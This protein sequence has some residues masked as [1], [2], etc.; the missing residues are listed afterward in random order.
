MNDT[1][2]VV[3][4]KKKRKLKPR[5]K[6][7]IHRRPGRG[8]LLTEAEIARALGELPRTVRTWRVK[9]FVPSLTLGHKTIRYR[10][11]PVL[12]ALE[13]R[14]IKKRYFFQQPI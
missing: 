11:G 13:K 6:W 9:G 2:E 3:A 7:K 1:D 14:Q 10:L 12:E 5:S 4:G 8:E